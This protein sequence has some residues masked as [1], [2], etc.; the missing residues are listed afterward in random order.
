MSEAER[1]L[2]M[3][4]NAD[5]DEVEC[6]DEEEDKAGEG[7]DEGA[8]VLDLP[9]EVRKRVKALKKIQVEITKIE[10]KF[11]EEMH[12]LE[13]KY[14]PMYLPH[15]EKRKV[16]VDGSYEPNEDECDFVGGSDSEELAENVGKMAIEGE[17][18]KEAVPKEE[19]V[20]GIPDFWLT[21][22]RNV[23]MLS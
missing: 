12:E 2:A 6:E 20:P 15:F 1:A 18:N 11:Y 7:D 21:I 14:L 10:A 16:I 3:G 9:P 13:C 22:F 19:K 8:A 23:E 4:D 17:E 5:H